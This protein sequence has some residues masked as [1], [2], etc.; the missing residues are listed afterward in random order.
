MVV[1]CGVDDID[2]RCR[3]ISV[4]HPTRTERIRRTDPQGYAEDLFIQEHKGIHTKQEGKVLANLM[5][6]QQ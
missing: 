6:M 1:S 2:D 5:I 4:V 3:Y